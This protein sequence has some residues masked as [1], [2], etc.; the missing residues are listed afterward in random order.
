[1][2]SLKIF[3]GALVAVVSINSYSDG[4]EITI[5]EAAAY[6]NEKYI[7]SNIRSECTELPKQFA[8]YAN[9]YITDRGWT[10]HSS[11]TPESV[12]QGNGLKLTIT[13][14]H[15]TGNAF[16]GHHKS[17]SITAELYQDGKVIDSYEGTRA[18]GGGFGGGFKSSCSVLARC[19]KTLG[20]DVSKWLDKREVKS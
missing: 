15:S 20:S 19:V 11:Q 12:D 17:V 2:R 3:I 6:E 1:M 4:K 5:S 10:V 7:Q 8:D 18:S 14:A 13:H 9:K 16:I